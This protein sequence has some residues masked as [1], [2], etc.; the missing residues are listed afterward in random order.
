MDRVYTVGIRT[1]FPG[2]WC[3]RRDSNPEPTDYESAALTVELQGHNDLR[4]VGVIVAKSLVHG[5][6]GVGPNRNNH[7]RL[8]RVEGFDNI[9]VNN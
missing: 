6:W 2:S 8:F 1:A 5:E 3:P 4:A 7:L 9:E